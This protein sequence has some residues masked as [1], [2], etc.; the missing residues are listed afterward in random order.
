MAAFAVS[1]VS[2]YQ[3]PKLDVVETMV[4]VKAVRKPRGHFLLTKSDVHPV[5]PI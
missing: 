1:G 5:S 3:D 2:F 4:M